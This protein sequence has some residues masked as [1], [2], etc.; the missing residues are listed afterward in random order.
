MA[1][2]R[3]VRRSRRSKMI[4]GEGIARK[5]R[6]SRKGRTTR[7]GR[8]TRKRRTSRKGRTTPKRRTSRKGRTSRRA[9][10]HGGAR[11]ALRPSEQKK[12]DKLDEWCDK[13]EPAINYLMAQPEG[14]P[15]SSAVKAL[16]DK[17]WSA[18]M[19]G[20]QAFDADRVGKV[21]CTSLDKF[22]EG[23]E[24]EGSEHYIPF[25]KELKCLIKDAELAP[26]WTPPQGWPNLKGKEKEA[27]ADATAELGD[28]CDSP[29][30]KDLLDKLED[31]PYAGVEEQVITF[32]KEVGDSNVNVIIAEIEAK[33]V[34][35]VEKFGQMGPIAQVKDAFLQTY[36]KEKLTKWMVELKMKEARK[37]LA[38]SEGEAQ[39]HARIKLAQEVGWDKVLAEDAEGVADSAVLDEDGEPAE[40]SDGADG[41]A[42]EGENLDENTENTEKT[43]GGA[44]QQ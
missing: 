25:Y 11:P 37:K 38:I 2:R 43:E 26:K 41:V 24:E 21:N 44:A 17:I 7:K 18:K 39:L 31:L 5:R 23:M 9:N 20:K 15:K 1:R 34:E 30:E 36:G 8:I 10:K 27:I 4:E 32:A 19:C 35:L 12:M 33:A 3:T 29:Q 16:S 6:T 28:G 13:Y 42:G 22:V 40:A 14:Y